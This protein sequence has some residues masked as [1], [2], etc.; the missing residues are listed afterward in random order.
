MV[1]TAKH[2]RPGPVATVDKERKAD[3]GASNVN[4]GAGLNE[5]L[6][7]FIF[8]CNNDTMREDLERQLFGM[9]QC[10][11]RIIVERWS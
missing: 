9:F 4:G 1:A 10:F 7:G 6:G 2:H 11:D 3:S 8:V 5:P